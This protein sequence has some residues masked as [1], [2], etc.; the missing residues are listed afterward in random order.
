MGPSGPTT[1]RVPWAALALAC[2]GAI[3]CWNPLAAPFALPVGA[4]AAALGARA[5]ARGSGSRRAA[6]AAAILGG[7]AAL[8]AGGVLVATWVRL[9]AAEPPGE[10]IVTSR[11]AAE[12]KSLLDG[13]AE[14][15]RAA[16]A[17]AQKELDRLG[18]QREA[19]GEGDGGLPGDEPRGDE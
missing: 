1:S 12:V 8:A 14:R 7:A 10:A 11:S 3:A 5:A 6:V 13:A 4:A 16:R 9:G 19:R 18:G 2:A 17:R 15:T